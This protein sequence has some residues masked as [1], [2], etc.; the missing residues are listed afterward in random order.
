[1]ASSGASFVDNFMGLIDSISNGDDILT[2]FHY[3]SG[4]VCDAAGMYYGATAFANGTRGAS[5]AIGEMKA[6]WQYSHWGSVVEDSMIDNVTY[7]GNVGY[8][9]YG[10]TSSGFCFVAGT[11]VKTPYGDKNIEDIETGDVVYACNVETGEVEEKEVVRTFINDAYTLIYVSVGNDDICAT[12]NHP[13]YV[14][15]KGFIP[16][17]DLEI[18]DIVVLIDGKLARVEQLDI[19]HL[20][21]PVKV[22]NFEVEDYHTYYVGTD[23]VLVHNMCAVTPP[24]R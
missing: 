5:A 17:G 2:I 23:G 7:E 13:F 12:L 3:A 18:R 19:K 9:C 1:M 10:D 4:T 21:E 11:I 22:Y 20:D 16:A 15:G 24:T 6:E 14:V 8:I